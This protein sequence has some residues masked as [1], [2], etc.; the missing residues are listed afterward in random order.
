MK[1]LLSIAIPTY[2]APKSVIKNVKRLLTYQN[3]RIEILVVDNDETGVQIKEEMLQM[4]D[5]RFHYYQNENNIGRNN[6]VAKAV[7]K[8]E[9][10]NVLLLSSDDELDFDALNEILAL[11]AECPFYGLILG[12][13]VT[14]MGGYGFDPKIAGTYKAGS[15]A[16]CIVPFLGNLMPMVVNKKYLD[17]SKLYGQDEQYM[18]LRIALLAAKKGDLI[19]LNNVLGTMS[20]NE[21]NMLTTKT[22]ECFENGYSDE[23]WDMKIGGFLQY[24]PEARIMQLK[25]YLRIIEDCC[26]RRDQKLKVIEKWVVSLMSKCLFAIA[27]YKS[28]FSINVDGYLGHLHYKDVLSNFENEMHVF[29]RERE[30]NGEY[31]YT[32]H[33]HDLVNNEL[34]LIEQAKAILQNILEADKVVIYGNGRTHKNLGNLLGYFKVN[35]KLSAGDEDLK[36]S[37]VLVISQS[38]KEMEQDLLEKGANKILFM[39]RMAKYLGIVWCS[40]HE[41]QEYWN[42]YIAY[43][44]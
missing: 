20:A 35:S 9:A 26:E 27:Q 21:N 23:K 5:P 7:E 29:F 19:Y 32:G 28:P 18:Q 4:N 11:L 8:A 1:P 44:D 37:L 6:N 25:S 24:S 30:K 39:D 31:F 33:L 36:G 43:M 34:L 14:D 22:D 41:G 38:N 16:L 42:E 17:F 2:G 15:D 12:T 13:I 40:E 10:D 3:E